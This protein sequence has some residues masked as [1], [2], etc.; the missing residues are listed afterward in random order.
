MATGKN[1]GE[2]LLNHVVLADDDFLQLLLHYAALMTEL[3]KDI[4][5]TPRLGKGSGGGNGGCR[6]RFWRHVSAVTRKRKK[7][8][9][10]KKS[11]K[12]AIGRT[13]TSKVYP[14]IV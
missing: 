10:G 3:L 13:L 12:R 9:P 2:H 6:G 11:A 4:P 5:Q 14:F 8:G 7:G 1:G